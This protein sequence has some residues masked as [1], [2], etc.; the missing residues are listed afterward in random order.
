MSER[1][2]KFLS[3]AG[4]CSRRA[5][6]RWIQDG[7]I[8]VNGVVITQQG[9]T[10]TNHD[11]IT[12]DGQ[13]VHA[14]PAPLPC[15]ESS[16]TDIP[17][18]V[19]VW[20]YHKPVGLLTTHHDPLGRPTVFDAI[21]AYKDELHLPAHIISV[22]RLDLNSEGLLILTNNGE[23]ARRLEHPSSHIPRTYRV[24]AFGVLNR[25]ALQQFEKLKTGIVIQGARYQPI[26][27][28]GDR[29]ALTPL[30]GCKNHWLRMTL[31]EGKNR[32]I[33]N[34]LNFLG[35]QVSRLIRIQ[36]GPFALDDLKPG[37]MKAFTR[38]C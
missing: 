7:R 4:V 13:P 10:I 33:R 34:V 26:D 27:V 30:P 1:L 32:E 31:H 18:G 8:A 36:Y 35:F 22:G 11:Q 19:Q 9:I 37:A 15:T 20:L 21:Q 5:A 25:T 14:P 29:G 23:Y 6:E 24:R 3:R 16:H 38:A 28:Q 12:V 17:P 2:H